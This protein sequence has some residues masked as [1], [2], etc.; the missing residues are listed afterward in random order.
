MVFFLLFPL[1]RR[2]PVALLPLAL[3]LVPRLDWLSWLAGPVHWLVLEIPVLHLVPFRRSPELVVH[4]ARLVQRHLERLGCPVAGWH[5]ERHLAPFAVRMRHPA[6][7]SRPLAR[8][9]LLLGGRVRL[10]LRR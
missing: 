3:E 7:P 10:W 8:L 6:P 1:R 5:P 2:R 9:E 4:F